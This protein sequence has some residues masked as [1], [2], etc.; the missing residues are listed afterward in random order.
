MHVNDISLTKPSPEHRAVMQDICNRLRDEI[1]EVRG[2]SAVYLDRP[3]YM[4]VGDL[5][6]YSGAAALLDHM[7]VRRLATLSV[8]DLGGMKLDRTGFTLKSQFSAIDAI[9]EKSDLLIF[10]GG[11][12][13]GDLW[14][15]HQYAREAV[16]KRYPGKRVIILPQTVHFEKKSNFER[17]RQLFQAHGNIRFLARDEESLDQM[18]DVCECGLAPDTAHMLWEQPQTPTH[19]N[20][21]APALHQARRDFEA[22]K[23]SPQKQAFDWEEMITPADTLVRHASEIT[24][25]ISL[26]RDFMATRWDNQAQDITS[27]AAR[28]FADASHVV[29]DR[30]HGMILSTIVE[31]PCEFEDNSYGKLG[32]YQRAWLR[33]TPL[34]APK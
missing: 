2:R 13:F 14:I 12:N 27:R 15:D 5:L 33:E 6:I 10:Q 24:R 7:K 19:K 17:M 18:K 4:N 1:S 26:F 31:T 16:I 3:V 29:T 9:V 23:S 8:G 11:G 34:V 21:T 22:A 20:A 32:R 30:L 28:R 25:R